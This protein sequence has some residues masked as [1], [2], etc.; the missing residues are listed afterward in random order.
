[1]K[2][3]N[4]NNYPK[5]KRPVKILQFGEGNFLRAFVEWIIQDMNDKGAINAGVAVV[6]PMPVG[7]VENLEAQNGLYTVCL[8]GIDKGETVKTRQIIDV[9]EDFINPFTQYDK[10]IEYAKS[11][12]LEVVISNTTEA[13]IALNADD[14]D[15]TKCPVSF[16]GKLLAFLKARYD[17]FSG[18]ESAGLAIIPC[19]LIDHNGAV[20]K[21]VLNQLA[22]ICGL[23]DKFINWMNNANHFTET[24]VDRIVPGYPRD[25]VESIW[26]ET[27]FKD[28]NVVKAE[29]FHL[30]VLKKEPFVQER[31]P[32]DSTGLNVIF[33]DDI[34]PYKQR[35]VKILNGSHTAMVPIAYLSG[36]DTVSESVND[37]DV[38]KFVSQL[39]YDIVSPTIDLPAD[40]MKSFADS[41]VERFKNP[42]IRHEL[43]SISLNSTTKFKTRLLPTYNDYI[44]KFGK[45]PRHIL[46]A[47]ASLV[48]FFR[49]KRGEENIALNDSPEYLDF[50]AKLWQNTDVTD[51]AKIALSA[52]DLWEQDLATDETV[53]LVASYISDILEIGER[54]AL[55]KFLNA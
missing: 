32:A 12:E 40:Q 34:T 53:S 43:M 28:D 13:G 19:E 30:W 49:G 52:S 11:E 20:L 14:T 10:Y 8:E 55:Q 48:V 5:T 41:V 9:L 37:A 47:F 17:H 23:D 36:I 46:F 3:L 45:A 38:G 21:D 50:W 24:L 27:G 44:A 33:A 16:P 1:M 39:I 26:E 15:F 22:K 42:F 25:T 29:C 51:I 7:R 35:K 31:F 6:Q 2:Q 54:A 18:A 4:S